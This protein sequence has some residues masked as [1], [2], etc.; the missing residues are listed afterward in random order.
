M[1]SYKRWG[2]RMMAIKRAWCAGLSLYFWS[3]RLAAKIN[4]RSVRARIPVISGRLA[5]I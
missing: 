1:V 3:M 4:R 5:N 2:E